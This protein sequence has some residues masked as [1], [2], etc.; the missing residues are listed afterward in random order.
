MS[1]ELTE[2]DDLKKRLM[3][4][5]RKLSELRDYIGLNEK[6]KGLKELE[7][8]MASPDFWKDN[9]HANRIITEMKR[10]KEVTE[11]WER[12][13]RE[14]EELKE[15]SDLT[16]EEDTSAIQDLAQ[17]IDLLLKN[18]DS[19]QIRAMLSGRHDASNAIL[20][21]HS[22]AG[23][24]ESC[25][26]AQMLFRMYT[27]WVEY[28][29]YKTQV[30]EFL[31]GEEAGI[32]S[33]TMTING[34]YVYGYL[35]AERGVH[36]LVRLSPFD[37]KKRRHTSFASVDVIPAIE[38]EVGVN[39]APKDLRID[40]YRATG[41]GG[42]GVN[43]TDSAVRITHIPTSIVVQCQNERSQ[44][45]NKAMAMKVLRARLYEL[46]E[47]KK[48]EEL[49]KLHGKKENIEWGSQIRSYILHPYN[50]VKDHRTGY[51]TSSPEKILNG[52]IDGFINAYL[53]R[54]NGDAIR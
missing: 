25:D 2:L 8:E 5:E 31:A 44:H 32:K 40:V 9:A 37:S 53:K 50:M 30:L 16:D 39:I 17:E 42:Q 6:K 47:R 49:T 7:E 20:F 19:F 28:K 24:T 1:P 54:K 35:K 14:L 52:E 21:I 15:L 13:F 3:K 29:G 33:V 11:P 45:K 22:G 10:L 12:L 43:T 27:R 46:E 51:E 4:A 36:R 41:P 26:W 48:K 23:G 34:D 18:V 38:D